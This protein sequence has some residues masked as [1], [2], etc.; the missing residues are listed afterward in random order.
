MSRSG[1]VEFDWADG[2]HA[3]RL[4]IGELEEL[5]EKTGAGPYELLR[6]LH[7]G[8]WR[9]AEVRETL[10]LGLI[11][12]GMAADAARRLVDRYAGPGQLLDAVVPALVVLNAA[13]AGAPDEPVGGP[14]GNAGAAKEAEAP[15]SPTAGSPSPPSTAPD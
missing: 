6:R 12:G 9:V 2:R 7:S 8:A 10:R 14:V 3:F 13:L 11:G 4:G 5:Q 1:K 15:P